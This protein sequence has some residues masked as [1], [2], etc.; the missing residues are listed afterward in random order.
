MRPTRIKAV[1]IA[2]LAATVLT[3]AASISGCGGDDEAST[4]TTGNDADSMFVKAMIPHHESAIEMAKIAK[5]RSQRSEVLELADAIV[6]TQQDEIDQMQQ[7]VNDLPATNSSMMDDNEMSAMKS[8]VED[9]STADEF[10][11]AFI[12][13]MIPHHQSA[14]EMAEEVLESG[15]SVDVRRLAQNVISA[16]QKEIAQ[17][18]KWSLNWYGVIPTGSTGAMMEHGGS[19]H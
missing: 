1:W 7:F 18:E 17:M 5:K 19:T 2:I 11:K 16:Q 9:L 4:S 10:D 3:I 13:A 14:V 6:K 8:D 12:A 15:E